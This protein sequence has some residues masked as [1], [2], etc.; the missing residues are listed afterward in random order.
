MSLSEDMG[1]PSTDGRDKD[2]K[3]NRTMEELVEVVLSQAVPLSADEPQI[4]NRKYI[5]IVKRG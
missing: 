5:L 4:Q 3:V 2:E 1:T